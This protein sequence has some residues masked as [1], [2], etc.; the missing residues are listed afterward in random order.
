MSVC[1]LCRQEAP[2]D[3]KEETKPFSENTC[4][5]TLLKNKHREAQRAFYVLEIFF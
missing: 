3:L 5:K 1:R 4:G 2:G